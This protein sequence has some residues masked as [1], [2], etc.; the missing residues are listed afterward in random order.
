[1]KKFLIIMLTIVALVAFFTACSVTDKETE[2]VSTTAITDEDGKT[3]YYE[4]VTDD[5]NQT[6][7]N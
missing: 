4:V 2:S 7:L 5:E 1:M 6:V 3:H